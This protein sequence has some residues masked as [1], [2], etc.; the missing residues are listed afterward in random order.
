MRASGSHCSLVLVVRP[1][2]LLEITSLVCPDSSGTTDDLESM[3]YGFPMRTRDDELLLQTEF[4]IQNSDRPT[5]HFSALD[6][7]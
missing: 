1:P 7:E 4:P 6:P 3:G 5:S 2:L